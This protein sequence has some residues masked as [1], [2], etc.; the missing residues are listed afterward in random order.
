MTS[1]SMILAALVPYL[2]DH[3]EEV[4]AAGQ[5]T[6][7]LK[8]FTSGKVKA[9]EAEVL[10]A[11]EYLVKGGLLVKAGDL[12]RVDKA[13]IPG[14]VQPK[15]SPATLTTKEAAAYLSISL[16]TLFRL[17]KAEKL[18]HL[19]IGRVLRFRPEDLDAFLAARV[20]TK[21]ED[22][23]AKKTASTEASKTTRTRKSPQTRISGH[24]EGT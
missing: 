19:R 12:Y 21:W 14:G 3:A 20:T 4:H 9:G 13:A 17:L 6:R 5:L 24:K 23:T 11:M 2:L 8:A 18:P 10:K 16:P 7:N 22:F 15:V 1:Q